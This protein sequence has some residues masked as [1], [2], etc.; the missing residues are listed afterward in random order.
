MKLRLAF[1][2]LLAAS[3]ALAQFD[4]VL[5]DGT[6]VPALYDLGKFSAGE[7]AIA[8][9]RLRNISA[10][11]ATLLS[12]T[13]AGAGFALSAPSVPIGIPAQSAIDITV[14]FSALGT[15]GYS[16][17]LHADGIAILLTS[18]V[19]PSLTCLTDSGPTLVPLTSLDFAS[20]VRGDSAARHVT[21]RNDSPGILTVPAMSVQGDGFSL[22]SPPSGQNLQPQ[23]SAAFSVVFSPATSGARQG[24]LAIGARTFPLTGVA[25]DPP[26]PNAAITIN[27]P[28]AASAQQGTLMIRYDAPAQST[29]TATASIAFSGS[30]D[31]KSADPA[32]A[33]A[34]GAR[35]VTLPVTP[36]DTQA[37]LPFQTGTTA[38][39][40]TFTVQLGTFSTQQS[41]TI[42]PAP[43]AVSTSQAVRA[44]GSI[45]I[46][47]TGFDNART[48]GPLTF[49][50]LDGAGKSLASLRSDATAD[51]A[52][53]FAAS[54]LGGVFLLR[55]VFPTTGDTSQI[56]ACDVTLGNSIG[57]PVQHILLQ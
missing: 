36:G 30:T 38:G 25:V 16:A 57:T 39:I 44:P 55:A 33:F 35:T 1:L 3:P 53:Y 49:T 20:V 18:T 46:R 10:A 29:G 8:H 52:K 24:T 26:L 56:A 6:P 51:F 5:P 2:F 45:E 37:A 28:A 15:G 11:P 32:I 21:L 27:L 4:L 23:Q 22:A 14:T 12:L 19:T 43:T 9:F 54:D 17:I 42:A 41:V 34:N 7:S 13:V 50:F 47:I 40:L 48:L 31:P